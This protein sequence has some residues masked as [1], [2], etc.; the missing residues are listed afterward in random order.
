MNRAVPIER[1]E[2]IIVQL[3]NFPYSQ[4]CRHSVALSLLS[5]IE[6][7]GGNVSEELAR[8]ITDAD[9]E[10]ALDLMDKNVKE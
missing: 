3:L 7:Y 4:I 1:L 2:G 5:L 9:D 10:K 8:A 6:E